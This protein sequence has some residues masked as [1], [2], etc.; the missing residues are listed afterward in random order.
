[1]AWHGRCNMRCATRPALQLEQ[2]TQA[3]Q[4]TPG[5]R[6]GTKSD[7]YGNVFVD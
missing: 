3:E 2:L 7:S 1:M 4:M 6:S 5:D